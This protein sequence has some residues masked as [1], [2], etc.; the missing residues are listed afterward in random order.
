MA[1]A[2]FHWSGKRD[3]DPAHDRLVEFLVMDIQH[4]PEWAAELAEKVAAV[5]SGAI[6]NWQRIGNAF[7]VELSGQGAAIEDTFDQ[8]RPIY[9]IPLTE[10]EQ[11][12]KAWSEQI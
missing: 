3:Q 7:C 1:T 8:A 5:R 11:A 10:F 2:P 6:P 9:T 12:I 4:S